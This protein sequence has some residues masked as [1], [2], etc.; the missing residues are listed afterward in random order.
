MR[1]FKFSVT[2]PPISL[3]HFMREYRL[4][5]RT[6]LLL[7]QRGLAEYVVHL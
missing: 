6:W 5:S 3:K 4:Y 2:W 1:L 7:S